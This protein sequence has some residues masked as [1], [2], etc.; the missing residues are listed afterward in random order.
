MLI[1]V[2]VGIF[3]F[4]TGL[5]IVE[6]LGVGLLFGGVFSI[7]YGLFD[8]WRHFSA[9]MKFVILM[10][11]LAMVLIYGYFHFLKVKRYER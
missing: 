7:I 9:I 6:S 10:F 4:I 5:L 2:I 8:Y 11:G 3:A 1:F